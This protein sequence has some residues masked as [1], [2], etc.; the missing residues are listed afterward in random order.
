LRHRFGAAKAK[1]QK[2]IANDLEKCSTVLKIKN[3]ERW[4]ARSS[5][6]QIKI[7]NK[8]MT[9]Y[10]DLE[11]QRKSAAWN[12]AVIIPNYDCNIWRRDPFGAAM[13]WVDHG[14]RYSEYG[15]EIDHIIPLAKG[16][17]DEHHNLQALHWRNNLAKSD[18]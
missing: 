8:R 2:E 7:R 15:W 5:I 17:V 12:R 4:R 1:E 18:R 3:S 6:Q 13:K 14:N 11:H 16:G 10:I 9:A